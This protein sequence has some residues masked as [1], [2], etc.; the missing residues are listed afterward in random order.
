MT[1]HKNMI[2]LMNTRKENS[3]ENWTRLFVLVLAVCFFLVVS[4][5]S[6][7]AQLTT[8]TITGTV[9]DTTGA[10][11]PGA[12][13]TAT[14]VDTHFTR[15]VATD[16]QGDY[17]LD[18]LPIGKYTVTVSEK[19]FST[20]EQENV[21]LVLN[22]EQTLSPSLKASSTESEITVT[23][24]PPMIQTTASS[25][26]RNITNVEVDNLPLVDR[27]VYQLV[28]LTPGVQSNTGNVALGIP[29]Q[30]VYINGGTDNE[31]GGNV[32]YY[33]DGGINMTFLRNSGNPLPNPDALQEMN[34]M[35]S[36]YDAR[37]G[38]SSAGVISAVTKS[39][40]NQ[41]HGSIFE[42]IRNDRLNATPYTNVATG[43]ILPR[44]HY[45]ENIF[46]ATLGG[47]IFKDKTFFFASYGG[48]RRNTPIAI[49]GIPVFSN[50]EIAS[51]FTNFSDR[52]P[53]TAITGAGAGNSPCSAFS[54]LTSAATAAGDIDLCTP[55]T[56]AFYATANNSIAASD[57]AGAVLVENYNLN[58]IGNPSCTGASSTNPLDPT[59]LNVAGNFLPAPNGT[60]TGGAPTWSGTF[61]EPYQEDEYLF[62]LSHN[63]THSQRIDASYF[64]TIGYST[65]NP[66][67]SF[68]QQWS[69]SH[70]PWRSQDAN[71]SDTWTISDNKV[72]Q[73]WLNY[74][75]MIGGRVNLPGTSAGS[76][77]GVTCPAPGAV[78][79]PFQPVGTPSLPQIALTSFFT[80]G[81]AISGP[82]VGTD[83]YGARDVFTWS[84]GKHTLAFGGEANLEKDMQNTTLNNYGVFTFAQGKSGTACERTCNALTDFILGL[85]STAKQD[86][87]IY[88]P[89]N[90]WQYGMFAQDDWKIRHNLTF[91]LG[92]RWD[93]QTPP[94]DPKNRLSAWRPGVQSVTEPLLPT[95]LNIVGDPGLTRGIVNIRYHHISPR[96]GFAWDVFGNGKTAVRGAGGVFYGIVSGNLWN[97]T[98]N[99]PPFATRTT[100]APTLTYT[101]SDPYQKWPG[102]VSPFNNFATYTPSASFAPLL[103]NSFSGIDP[104][105]QWPYTYQFN[106]SVQQQISRNVTIS[107]SYI[108][109]LSHRIPFNIDADPECTGNV[110]NPNAGET[111]VPAG[112]LCTATAA[113]NKRPLYNQAANPI[114]NQIED[115]SVVTSG[116]TANYNALQVELEKR[117]SNHFAFKGSYIWSRT[118]E[119]AQ[120][121]STTSAV[122]PQNFEFIREDKGR[123]DDDL[124]NRMVASLVWKPDYFTKYN[125]YTRS[126]LNGWTIAADAFLQSGMPFTVTTGVNTNNDGQGTAK[127]RASLV[128][129]VNPYKTY[130]N[131][132]QE[133]GGFLNPLAFCAASAAGCPNLSQTT[134]NAAQSLDGTTQRDGFTGPGFKDINMSLFRDFGI[135]GRVK[136]QVRAEAI[137]AFNFVD[138]GN[139]S[140]ALNSATFGKITG[141]PSGS[142][143]APE[144]G[145]RIMQ[146]GARLLF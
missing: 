96:A 55:Q 129:G 113:D 65:Q 118:M 128:P 139:P 75:R 135:Y 88:I 18:F 142:T 78:D 43:T 103:P 31:L 125:R 38:R 102:G 64:Q 121:Q 144:F 90:T 106:L 68:P 11:I 82:L 69:H 57:G 117:L 44:T 124:R 59:A 24:A 87:G 134:G 133:V 58:C 127:D 45:H 105:Y 27:S 7:S 6:S 76:L 37:Y 15:S 108:A 83:F 92:I 28:S 39:G 99:A 136:L 70:Y 21:V 60:S 13:V 53:A 114:A 25:V 77:C 54:T 62:K 63:L 81:E 66:G 115:V 73:V 132:G 42:F 61:S 3:Q 140:A 35:T 52:I 130:A 67:G 40:T 116:Q 131:R 2:N 122:I 26:G 20:L 1:F 51:G 143:L 98:S 97:Q 110:P 107:V 100:F 89:D 10:I 71:L 17:R 56:N 46:G 120:L 16:G 95:G 104:N 22:Q 30:V 23:D 145:P 94:T 34:V 109:S 138:L 111:G 32:S 101:L 79:G 93:I 86:T 126:V 91:N 29:Q 19:G 5:A 12:T 141:G 85:N 14:N 4:A 74:T 84:K 50:S 48:I 112:S 146:F 47:P 137:N 33:L 41:F 80:L 9:T 72:N 36:S 49:T 123:S 119:S 8:A